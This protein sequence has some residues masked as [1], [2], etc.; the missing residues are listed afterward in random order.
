MTED[1]AT[2]PTTDLP[3]LSVD[4][5]MHRMQ[6]IGTLMQRAM[7][8]DVD[9][10]AIPGTNSKPTLLK[11]GA[12]K[13]LVLFQLDAQYDTKKTFD[14]GHLT[15]ETYCT[16]YHAPTGNRLGG[17][18]A[19]C[20]TLEAKYRYRGGAR[21]CP[22]CGKP[23]IKKSKFPPRGTNLP[24]GF[25]CFGKIGGCGVNYAH[26][27]ERITSQSEERQENPDIADTYN[28]VLRIAEKRALVAA[29]RQVTGASAVFDEEP[30]H[31]EAEGA[32]E[33]PQTQSQVAEAA[34]RSMDNAESL[35]DLQTLWKTFPKKVQGSAEVLEA[36]NRRKAELNGVP[37]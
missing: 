9:Y 16:I 20:S 21:I 15:V 11:P 36:K 17:A 6:T 34:I 1:L 37:A 24:P 31:V 35:S 25:Y 2:R 26:D 18:S 30:P 4:Q 28:T 19:V 29:V 10:G 33:P 3:A 27:D 8:K 22:E 14:G 5:V 32:H 23:A 13:L 12:E 7:L